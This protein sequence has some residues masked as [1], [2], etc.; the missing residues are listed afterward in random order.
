M[1]RTK[2]QNGLKPSPIDA[3]DIPEPGTTTELPLS[4]GRVVVVKPLDLTGELLMGS[5]PDQVI[6]WEAFRDLNN[7][8]ATK[9]F[10]DRIK[11]LYESKLMTVAR[12][13]VTPKL[14]LGPPE[15]ILSITPRKEKGEIGPRQ[16]KPAEI[17]E[18]YNFLMWGVLPDVATAPFPAE[19]DDD[20]ESGELVPPGDELPHAPER[21]AEA[22]DGAGTPEVAQTSGG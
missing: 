21:D 10:Q 11:S 1:P 8:A 5:L 15:N 14:A 22:R 4:T 2:A 12:G 7:G 16:L 6:R 3:W 20:G 18:I 19:S 17:D 13:L 9:T